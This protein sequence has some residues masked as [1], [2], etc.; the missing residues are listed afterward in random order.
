L[1]QNHAL[2]VQKYE[3]GLGEWYFIGIIAP[4]EQGLAKPRTFSVREY[5]AQGEPKMVVFENRSAAYVLYER[6]GSADPKGRASGN[7]HLQAG[8][9]PLFTHAG[10][11]QCTTDR[12]KARGE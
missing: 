7:C 3:L 12:N 9:S 11:M 10:D 6:S 4:K 8:I 5:R 2:I 1:P